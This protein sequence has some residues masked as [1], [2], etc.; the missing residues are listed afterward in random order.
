[1]G[2]TLCVGLGDAEVLV[3]SGGID[4]ADEGC[5]LA[6]LNEKR[7]GSFT[8]CSC[9]EEADGDAPGDDAGRG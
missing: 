3:K 2:G 8:P 4:V 1:M 9:F 5:L 6:W 7:K